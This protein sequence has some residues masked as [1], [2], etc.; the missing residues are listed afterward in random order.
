MSDAI[1][2]TG[3][4]VLVKRAAA[5][6]TE[7]AATAYAGGYRAGLGKALRIVRGLQSHRKCVQTCKVTCETCCGQC[8]WCALDRIAERI[9]KAKEAP[10]E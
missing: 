7:Q 2:I 3:P 1:K 4:T 8:E 9:K 10:G 5:M 6:I